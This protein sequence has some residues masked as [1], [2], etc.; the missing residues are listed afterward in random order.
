VL[1]DEAQGLKIAA[2]E[3][4]DG[5]K[6]LGSRPE[7]EGFRVEPRQGLLVE[8]FA[9]REAAQFLDQLGVGAPIRGAHADVD[10][11][12]GSFAD[13]VVRPARARMDLQG[14][15]LQPA[16]GQELDLRDE[17]RADAVAD[18]AGQTLPQVESGRHAANVAGAVLH[19]DEQRA[20]GRVGE[21]DDGPFG[22]DVGIS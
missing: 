10:S 16:P 7:V 13:Q 15:H 19:A 5:R 9:P 2:G 21:G 4:A 17:A 3:R 1:R 22:D 14:Q 20:A 8:P 12:G 6:R 18:E 11:G